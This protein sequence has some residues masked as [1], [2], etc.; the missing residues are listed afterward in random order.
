MFRLLCTVPHFLI[1]PG[2]RGF[3]SVLLWTP[4]TAFGLPPGSLTAVQG[5]RP[6]ASRVPPEL[7]TVLSVSAYTRRLLHEHAE[8]CIVDTAIS[9]GCKNV[10]YILAIMMH[11]TPYTWKMLLREQVVSLYTDKL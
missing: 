11:K 7:G 10:L 5:L 8:L 2:V 6:P 1:D 9:G 3:N 4:S